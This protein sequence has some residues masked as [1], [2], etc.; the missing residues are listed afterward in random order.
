MRKYEV[1]A[2][3][4]QKLRRLTALDEKSFVSLL[5]SVVT[6]LGASGKQAAMM[7]ANSGAIRAMIS[8][9]SDNDIRKLASRLGP[10]K[11]GEI[12]AIIDEKLSGDVEE[13]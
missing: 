7:T 12:L 2:E 9:A 10:Q 6:A 8:R 1:S 4:V 11:T 5:S 13:T 3:D